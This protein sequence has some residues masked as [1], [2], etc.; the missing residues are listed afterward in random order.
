MILYRWNLPLEFDSNISG[1]IAL[2]HGGT[3]CDS[4]LV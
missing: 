3:T 2:E 1:K 4:G